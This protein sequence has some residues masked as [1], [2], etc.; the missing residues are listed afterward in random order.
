MRRPRVSRLRS[1]ATLPGQKEPIAM[2]PS[3]TSLL[4][5]LACLASS[6]CATDG[7]VFEA[8][9]ARVAEPYRG[10][11]VS[12]SAVLSAGQRHVCAGLTD[13]TVRCWGRNESGQLG[14]GTQQ[15]RSRPV[16]VR[17]LSG[18]VQVAAGGA[19]TCALLSNGRVNCWGFG[20]DC[21][22]ADSESSWERR[23][24]LS[25]AVPV[26][27]PGVRDATQIS[28]GMPFVCARIADGT[29]TCWGRSGN[30]GTQACSSTVARVPGLTDVVE[31]QSG[32]TGASCARKRDGTVWCWVGGFSPEPAFLDALPTQVE[33]LE[34]VTAMAIGQQHFGYGAVGCAVLDD[35]TV[36][37][38]N[39]GSNNMN[40]PVVRTG[41]ALPGTLPGLSSVTRIATDG[42][43]VCA[44]DA[45]GEVTCWT[46]ALA[47]DRST[48]ETTGPDRC[49]WPSL[50]GQT[51]LCA[52]ASTPAPRLSGAMGLTMGTY[53][54][55]TTR[56]DGL[57]TCF[58]DNPYGQLGN[59]RTSDYEV[60][61]GGRVR[62]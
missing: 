10:V 53:F 11:E 57:P 21:A 60:G 28:V 8:P 5:L 61:G 47:W 55:C 22:L 35:G 56:A 39:N 59:G 62:W 18:V 34:H 17:G 4:S 36:R 29:V 3:I 19:V 38:W 27:I 9:V 37:C 14:D 41:S 32:P 42:D 13:G 12:S 24:R 50:P 26:E 16:A 23:Q 49:A 7:L 48:L 31:V 30:S 20:G 51:Y 44:L 52:Y 15:D 58:G 43:H 54:T 40:E 33:G 25:S 46:H 1:V 6:S 2:R 45:A